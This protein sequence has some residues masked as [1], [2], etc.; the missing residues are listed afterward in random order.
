MLLLN[1]KL[2]FETGMSDFHQLI[3]TIFKVKTD[4]LPPRII[5]YIDYENSE[6]KA[7]TKKLQVCLKNFHMN[8]SSF[9]EFKTT[10]ME[11]LNKVVPLKNRYLRANSSKF[12]TKE[13]SKAIMLRTK[14]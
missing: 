7:F 5:K 8:V 3:I 6:R 11:L 14:L 4:K 13:L 12:M 10:F 9:N 2:K 1:I